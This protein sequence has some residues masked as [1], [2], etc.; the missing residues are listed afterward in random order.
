MSAASADLVVGGTGGSVGRPE[1]VPA[2]DSPSELAREATK[3]ALAR[4]YLRWREGVVSDAELRRALGDFTARSGAVGAG[5]GLD[6]RMVHRGVPP[7]AGT[8][9]GVVPGPG[10]GLRFLG[11]SRTLPVRHY[12]QKRSY[13]CGPAAA[14]SILA[15][16]HPGPSEYDGAT[17]K[18][19][20]LAGR[21][22]LRTDASRSTPWTAGRMRVALNRWAY[23]DSRYGWYV[24]NASPTVAEFRDALAT[25][26]DFG[27]PFAADTV[28]FAGGAHYNN[29]PVNRTIGHWIVVSGYAADGATTRFVDPARSEAVSWGDLPDAG[30]SHPTD[31]FVRRHLQHNGIV[32]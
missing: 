10:T 9:V 29:H 18:Q 32:W 2:G 11:D 27:I 21:P 4:T 22:Y 7:L 13:Y 8:D 6:R 1:T 3:A 19:S 24:N 23:G 30:F 15:L 26:I 16:L 28:E 25:N 20:A 31:A 17:L 12:A 5:S 14:Q